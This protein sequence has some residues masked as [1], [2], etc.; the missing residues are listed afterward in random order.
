MSPYAQARSKPTYREWRI[1][2]ARAEFAVW[3]RV[4]L[5]AQAVARAGQGAKPGQ[6]KSCSTPIHGPVHYPEGSA[7]S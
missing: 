3:P 7:E 4:P 5:P 1:G 6:P 2:L